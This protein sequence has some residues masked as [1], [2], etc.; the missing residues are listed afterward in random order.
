M[1]EYKEG[2]ENMEN[3][4]YYCYRCG[5]LLDLCPTQHDMNLVELPISKQEVYLC[6]AC[7]WEETQRQQEFYKE[8]R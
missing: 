2:E 6:Q 4:E 1:N 5:Q 7:Y 3:E 8:N